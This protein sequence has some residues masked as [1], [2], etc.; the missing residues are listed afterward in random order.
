MSRNTGILVHPTSFPSPY[1]IGDLGDGAYDF[2]DFLAACKLSLWQV[3]PL[4]PTSFG[5][6]PY[7]SFST[8][9]G[10]QLLIS[11]ELLY[12]EGYLE[13]ADLENIPQF[14][15]HKVDYGAVINY[16]NTL[17]EKAFAGFKEK[18][19]SKQRTAFSRFCK[20]NSAWLTDYS[21][22]VSLKNHFINER[23]FDYDSEAFLAYKAFNTEY[24]SENQV[25]DYYYGAVWNS[26]PKD[27]ALREKS[28]IARYKEML[29]DG[30]ELV[31]FLQYEFYRQW[32]KLKMYANSKGIT[33]VGDIPIFVAMDSS[34]VWAQ[35]ELFKLDKNGYPTAVAGVP[36]D[37]FSETGQLWGNPLYDWDAHAETGY[38]WW[39]KRMNSVLK[40]ADLI[41]IDHFRG[42]DAYYAIPYGEKTAV[43]G[44]WI[45][46]PS[47]AFI[48][49][50]RNQFE[51]LPII[52]ED[53][54]VITKSVNELRSFAKL[55]GMKI[56]QFAF[57]GEN[58]D[59]YLPHNLT[60]T[61]T[62]VYTGTHD[63]DTSAGWYEHAS[64]KTKDY[65]R[66]YMNV[67][68]EDVAWDFIRLAFSSP[69]DY[70][71]VPIQDIF[72][73]GSDARM[74]LPGSVSG[75]WQFRYTAD[76]LHDGLKERILYLGS[77]F[78]RQA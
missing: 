22:F 15:L 67:S 4:G 5:D 71:I 76:M 53:L 65:F 28:A 40:T 13:Q 46:G 19:T 43:N 30:I 70:V 56:L 31:S 7:Q 17:Y 36:P 48:R 69:A 21:L 20:E 3:L 74:N 61:H 12:K 52:A 54:G 57:E 33:I 1:G 37:Y 58:D 64:E 34:D 24:L 55:P 77:L 8:F 9:A 16:K 27:I 14:D 41:R 47:K 26:W 38:E 51:S 35:P 32:N 42:F 75:N 62:V 25:K 49:A 6:S 44:K 18:A 10:N 72:G 63:N 11:P 68:G 45:K 59:V 39:I 66:K 78:N 2:I 23:R 60:D 73:L 50:L 29:Q